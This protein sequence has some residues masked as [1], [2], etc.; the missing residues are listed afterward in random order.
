ML[1]NAKC[2]HVGYHLGDFEFFKPKIFKFM[3]IYIIWDGNRTDKMN[4]KISNND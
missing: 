4:F 3:I 1:N 2:K